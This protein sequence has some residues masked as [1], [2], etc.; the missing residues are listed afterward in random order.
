[1]ILFNRLYCHQV[2]F[3]LTELAHQQNMGYILFLLAADTQI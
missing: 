3:K 1:M 2:H